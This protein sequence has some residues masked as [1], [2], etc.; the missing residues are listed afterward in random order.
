[1][2][3]QTPQ[4]IQ[5]FVPQSAPMPMDMTG[6]HLSEEHKRKI[7]ESKKGGKGTFGMLGKYHTEETKRRIRMRLSEIRKGSGNPM[8]GRHASAETRRKM[9]EA[10]KGSKSHRF[11]KHH[12]EETRKKLSEANKGKILSIETRHK[13]GEASKGRVHSE[14]S[15]R[16]FSESRRGE[17][18]PNFG[19]HL[20]KEI[21]EKIGESEK[22][23][24]NWRWKG[25]LP[26]C[27]DCGKRLSG[28]KEKRCK[29]CAGKLHTGVNHH[30]WK[31]G[32]TSENEKIRKSVDYDIWQH[33]VFTRDSY[34]DVKTGIQGGKLHAHHILNFAE[35]P[36]LR[37]AIDN[38]ITLSEKSHMEF[39]KK[40]GRKYNTREQLEEFL[41]S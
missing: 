27:Q 1:M 26:Y 20:S 13:I 7:S 35:Y 32:I 19:K 9:S 33:A 41:K 8:F 30:N 10:Q 5:P 31:G 11:G 15:R 39:H 2:A 14:E 3:Q 23:E 36:E 21:R 6:K 38:G 12:S 16:K 22:G 4:P 28:Y 34:T 40:Y 18:N 25:G 37:F 17:K 24:K 29:K